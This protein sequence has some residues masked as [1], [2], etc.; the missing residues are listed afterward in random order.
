MKTLEWRIPDHNMGQKV[1]SGKIG[2][3]RPVVNDIGPVLVVWF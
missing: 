3:V 1:I 2:E